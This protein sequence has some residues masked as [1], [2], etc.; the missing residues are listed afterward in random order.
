MND[1]AKA[2]MDVNDNPLGET[3]AE[4]SSTVEMTE[5]TTIEPRAKAAL[6]AKTDHE[7]SN[8]AKTG[9]DQPEIIRKIFEIQNMKQTKAPI[10][11]PKNREDRVQWIQLGRES[12]EIKLNV[13]IKYNEPATMINIMTY[14]NKE[15]S[16]TVEH[17]R[18]A[19]VNKPLDQSRKYEQ[20][21]VGIKP[22][23]NRASI[24]DTFHHLSLPT[25]PS[26]S[27][28]LSQRRKTH[29]RIQTMMIMTRKVT[30][31]LMRT[32]PE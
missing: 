14:L 25:S 23:I 13:D 26:P 27:F 2:K 21:S 11:M 5:I 20:V 6:A 24:Q 17:P 28:S 16:V 22:H 15:D 31:L 7:A 1:A 30:Q 19:S 9:T 12:D 18:R 32:T 4:R 3:N 8:M 10:M 29:M